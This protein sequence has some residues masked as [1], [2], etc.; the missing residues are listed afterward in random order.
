MTERVHRGAVRINAGVSE[1]RGGLG[2]WAEDLP[3]EWTEVYA[4]VRTKA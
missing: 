3:S 2:D 1:R 4:N